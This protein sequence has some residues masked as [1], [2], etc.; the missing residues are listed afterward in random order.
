MRTATHTDI[1]KE[2]A[3][4]VVILT[5]GTE[6][7]YISASEYETWRSD[8]LGGAQKIEVEYKPVTDSTEK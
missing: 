4:Y 6:T 5:E 8:T 7:R 1:D 3:G 2:N